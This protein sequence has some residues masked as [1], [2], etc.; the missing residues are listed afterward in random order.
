MKTLKDDIRQRILAV[1][2]QEFIT[3][4]VRN[5]SVRTIAHKAGIAVGNVY[6]YFESKDNLFCEV[7]RPLINSLN[8]YILSHNAERH[9]NLEVFFEKHF[10][11]EY[12]LSMK[13]LVNKYRPELRLLLFNAEDTSLAGYA[14]RIVEH[15]T[16]IG[17][18]YLQLM[19]KRYPHIDICIS[20]FFLHIV[21]ST[22]VKFFAEL[23]E[24]DE[25]SEQEVQRALMQYAAYS[26]A[27]W[28]AIMKV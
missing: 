23:V 7:L 24:H 12:I 11:E 28:K 20:P 3:H 2:R 25:Y 21:S 14:N 9:L 27:G 16:R 1:A 8:T 6:N 17:T 10:Q 26:M 15:Q 13:T 22:W 19:K 18:E 4:G 5:T